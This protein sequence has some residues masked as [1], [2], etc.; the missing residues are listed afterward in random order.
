[1]LSHIKKVVSTMKL[2][3]LRRAVEDADA[4]L[5]AVAEPAARLWTNVAA[6]RSYVEDM[7]KQLHIMASTC[8]GNYFNEGNARGHIHRLIT[9]QH[10]SMH[11]LNLAGLGN[12]VTMLTELEASDAYKSAVATL[13][14]LFAAKKAAETALQD[15]TMKLADKQRALDT[16]IETAKQ[17]ALASAGKHP[18]VQAALADLKAYDVEAVVIDT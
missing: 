14:P 13:E 9:M 2:Q 18:E 6:L 12:A 8:D 11:G 10:N 15:Y 16:A 4:K 1:M 7:R 5:G 3:S 17:K